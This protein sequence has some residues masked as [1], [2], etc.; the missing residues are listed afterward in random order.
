MFKKNF[1]FVSIVFILILVCCFFFFAKE[2]SKNT[3]TFWTIQLKPVAEKFIEKNIE[4]FKQ[5]HKGVEVIWVDIPIAEAQ[6]RILASILGGN[7]PDLVNLNPD[8]SVILAQKNALYFFEENDVV[9]FKKEIIDLL[10]YDGHIYGIPFYATSSITILNTECVKDYRKIKKYD[11]I[12]TLNNKCQ[13]NL[14]INLNEND[15]FAKIL[16]KYNVFSFK[17]QE[18]LNN[19]KAVFD[20]FKAMYENS[21]IPKDSLTINH[22]E[23]VEKYMAGDTA[24]VVVGGNFVKMIEEN[25]KNIYDKSVILPQLTGVNNYYDVSLMNFVIPKKAKNIELA[26]EFLFQLTNEK[27]QIEFAKLTNVLAVNNN[28]LKDNFFV[29]DKKSSLIDSARCVGAMQLERL[30]GKNFG[31]QNKKEINEIL[32]GAIEEYLL[33]GTLNLNDIKNKIESLQ[34]P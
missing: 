6:K 1:L 29:C 11:D 33:Q 20:M 14:S 8:F 15:T 34:E 16:N 2:K 17:T 7:P 4:I 9:D 23:V 27:N 19:A 26:R 12:L 5:K 25:A 13:N 21:L 18:E 31:Y 30:S 10:R 28:S 24:V 22:R 32:N 3:L